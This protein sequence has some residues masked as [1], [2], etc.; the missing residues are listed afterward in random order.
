MGVGYALLAAALL[1]SALPAATFCPDSFEMRVV[2]RLPAHAEYS[3]CAGDA[4]HDGMHELYVIGDD[5]LDR[6]VV[7]CAEHIGANQFEY[8]VPGISRQLPWYVSDM[9]RDGKSELVTRDYSYL[10]VYESANEFSLPSDLVWEDTLDNAYAVPCRMTDLDG[11]SAPEICC[12]RVDCG[13][14]YVVGVYENTGDNEYSLVAELGDSL[15]GIGSVVQTCDLDRDGRPELAVSTEAGQVGFFEAVGDDTFELKAAVL[16][17]WANGTRVTATPDMDSDGRP[18]AVVLGVYRTSEAWVGVLESPCDDSFAVVWMSQFQGAYNARWCAVSGD[19]DGDSVSEFAVADGQNLR[20]F[21]CT[22]PDFYEQFW[23]IEY[24]MEEVLLYDINSDGRDELIHREGQLEMV[25]R[26]YTEVGVAELELRRL[27]G[28]RVVPS[29]V[30]RGVAVR[31]EGL[32][33]G[34]S[35]QVL[36]AAGRVVAEPEDGVWRT[37][38]VSPGVYFFR[39]GLSAASCRPSAVPARKVLVVE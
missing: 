37:D 2:A 17:A 15:I 8:E 10:R 1:A 30:R 24:P 29:V 23:S 39:F 13:P 12:G 34:F 7:V 4:D 35:V 36:D 22:G 11:D 21:R 9:D 3:T 20:L 26:E 18:E 31:L 33:S 14:P 28:V 6:W 19:V 5:T 16:V 38:G 27:E 25:V 32:E